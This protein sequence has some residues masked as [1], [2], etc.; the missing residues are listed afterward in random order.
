LGLIVARPYEN[1]WGYAAATVEEELTHALLLIAAAWSF[2]GGTY[3]M[4]EPRVT[5]SR[6]PGIK[7]N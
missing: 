6:I 7:S 5:I 2:S 1:N 3:M 4:I